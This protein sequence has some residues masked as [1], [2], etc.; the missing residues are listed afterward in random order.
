MRAQRVSTTTVLGR[1][2]RLRTKKQINVSKE[3]ALRGG[4]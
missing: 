3:S 2:S 4:E 1:Q